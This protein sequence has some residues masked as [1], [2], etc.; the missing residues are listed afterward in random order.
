MKKRIYTATITGAILGIFCIIGVGFRLGFSGNEILLFST[1]FNRIVMGFAIGLASPIKISKKHNTISRGLLFGLI[2]S[3]AHYASS[4]FTDLI[5]FI[6]GIFYGIII[7]YFA[8]KAEKTSQKKISNKNKK[9]MSTYM[10]TIIVVLGLLFIWIAYGFFASRFVEKLGYTVVETKNKYEI[11]LLDDHL[12]AETEVKG[13]FETGINEGFNILAGYIFGD[14]KKKQKI[15]MTTPVVGSEKQ[16]E[17]IEMTAPVIG[18][19]SSKET[20]L[21]SFVLPS[22]Y[23]L[24]EVPEP[25][26]PKISIREIK[27]KKIAVIKFSGFFSDEKFEKKKQELIKYLEKDGVK[28]KTISYVGYNPPWTPPFMRR[29]EVWAELIE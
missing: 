19:E 13:T 7:D 3:F 15:K 1:W 23:N 5:G 22:K 28:Y 21:F 29:N 14:N 6:A 17:K 25:N 24:D 10:I 18:E 8:T 16:S 26:N 9:R 4:N 12:I 27:G 11:R 20:I 2:F